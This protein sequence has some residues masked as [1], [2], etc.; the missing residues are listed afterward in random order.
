MQNEMKELKRIKAEEGNLAEIDW[1]ISEE[2]NTL[3][4]LEHKDQVEWLSGFASM[5]LATN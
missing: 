3:K 5:P 2:M 1:E 4:R